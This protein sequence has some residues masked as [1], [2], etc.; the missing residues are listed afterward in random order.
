MKLRSAFFLALIIPF[1]CSC[2]GQRQVRILYWNI[3]NGMWAD[4][5]S[6]YDNFVQ[7]VNDVNPDICIWCEAKTHYRTG[8]NKSFPDDPDSLYLPSHWAELAARYG[9]RY[10]FMGGER[11]FFPQVVTSRYPIEGMLR[12]TGDSAVTVSHGAG[13]ARVFAGKDT[14]NIVTVHTWP[15]QYGLNIPKN[16]PALRQESAARSEGHIARRRE[17]QWI[18]EHTI[19]TDPAAGEHLWILAGDM[20]S[21]SRVD[22]GIYGI[23]ED[24]PEFLTQDYLA[25]IPCLIDAQNAL[26]DRF[27]FTGAGSGRRIDYIYCTPP[28]FDRVKSLRV[29]REGFPSN[30]KTA[31]SNFWIPSDHYPIIVDLDLR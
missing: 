15:Q 1:L 24:S 31:I 28:V 26:A 25:T 10:V 5:G 27:V 4:Q 18:V 6:N 23:E 22:N 29:D 17:M 21:I 9:H 8:Q 16:P 14:L 7:Y 19:A 3:Q 13:W 20:N 2:S 12:M 30:G 11:D